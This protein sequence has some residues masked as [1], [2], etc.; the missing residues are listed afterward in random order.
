MKVDE[1]VW[2]HTWHAI[3]D[4][5]LVDPAEGVTVTSILGDYHSLEDIFLTDSDWT[6]SKRCFGILFSFDQCSDLTFKF[7]AMLIA[8]LPYGLGKAPW[9]TA[10]E[11]ADGLQQLLSG[12]RVVC[13]A[14]FHTVVLYVS[15]AMVGM[16]EQ[17]LLANNYV[18]IQ[19]LPWFKPGHNLTG[20]AYVLIPSVGEV[21][22]IAL[23]GA[24]QMELNKKFINWDKNPLKRPNLL[25]CP[26]VRQRKVDAYG[27]VINQHEKPAGI[28]SYLAP[29][30]CL[31]GSTVLVAGSGAF[32]DVLG[33][34]GA[35]I[36]VVAIE[37][38][39]VQFKQT[40][41]L[42]PTLKLENHADAVIPFEDLNTRLA[43][44]SDEA[45]VEVPRV[46]CCRCLELI[47]DLK[48]GCKCTTCGV[49]YICG[50]CIP[51]FTNSAPKCKECASIPVATITGPGAETE[52]GAPQSHSETDP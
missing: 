42:I 12:F 34:L 26:T 35:G 29:K 45:P 32:G 22:L 7:V 46:N 18:H 30:L 14:R 16:A 33:I 41:I 49:E 44:S 10:A 13:T 1:H 11:T 51:G 40:A 28:M 8:D 17:V 48:E 43:Q 21:L 9:D 24:T 2:T 19:Q 15:L 52:A 3:E 47:K 39:P 6:E 4:F 50:K 36:H 27:K 31:E 5:Q 38:D 37:N 20:P 25:V 23:S